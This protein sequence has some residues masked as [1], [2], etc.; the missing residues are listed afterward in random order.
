MATRRLTSYTWI[1]WLTKLLAGEEHCFWKAWFKSHFQNYEK[2][3]SDFDSA[4]WAVDHAAVVHDRAEQLRKAGWT[5]SVENQNS[6]VLAGR[7]G[8]KLA[9]KPDIVALREGAQVHNSE[10]LIVEIKGP[11]AKPRASH[12]IQALLYLYL[13]AYAH[14]EHEN[15]T[16]YAQVEYANRPAIRLSRDDAGDAFRQQ[17]RM[18]MQE[19]SGDAEPAHTPSY[20]ECSR[21]DLGLSVCRARISSVVEAIPVEIF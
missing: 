7:R 8:A 6:F 1:T 12:K 4:Q 15:F 10:I 9:G 13:Y 19:I 3:D 18:M 17:F 21:C 16:I 5:V 11:D 2:V 20:N 14:P